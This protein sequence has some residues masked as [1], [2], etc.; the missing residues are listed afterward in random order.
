MLADI[1]GQ[2]LRHLL[3]SRDLRSAH[4][5]QRPTALD[6]VDQVVMGAV[7]CSVRKKRV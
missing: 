3:I 2:V 4:T 7:L 5:V 6:V 1:L